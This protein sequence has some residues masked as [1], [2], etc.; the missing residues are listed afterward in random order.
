MSRRFTSRAAT[1][2]IALSAILGVFPLTS[3]AALEPIIY[4]IRIPS[5]ES[6]V[7]EIE[8]AIP[9]EKRPS[10]ELMMAVWSPGFY[11]VEDYAGKVQKLTARTSA[12]EELKVEQTRKN[13]RCGPGYLGSRPCRFRACAIPRGG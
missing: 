13:N 3:R 11:R 7:A 5:P 8:I 2:A 4:S 10:I 9:T 6:H 1:A 12:G